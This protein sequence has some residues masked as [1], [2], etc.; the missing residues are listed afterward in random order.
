MSKQKQRSRRAHD[1]LAPVGFYTCPRCNQEKLPHRICD[2][3]G[4]YRDVEKIKTGG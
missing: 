1:A 4:Y 3:C 2:N